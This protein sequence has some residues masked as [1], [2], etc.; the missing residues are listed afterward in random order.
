MAIKYIGKGGYFMP[1]NVEIPM[2]YEDFHPGKPF[3]EA[4]ADGDLIYRE[5][6]MVYVDDDGNVFDTMGFFLR[7][8]KK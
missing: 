4:C 1:K 3:N 5:S 2:V 7:N 6:D 8:E